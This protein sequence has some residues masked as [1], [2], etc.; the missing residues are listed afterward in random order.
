MNL[1]KLVVTLSLVSMVSLTG[2]SAVGTA[3]KKR[4]LEVSTKMSQTIWLEPAD[5]KTVY[6]QIKNTSDKNIDVESK[7]ISALQAKGYS[8]TQDSKNAQYWIQANVLKVDKMDLREAES[9]LASGYGAAA[10]GAVTAGSV[11]AYNG[12]STGAVLG[13]GIVGGLVGVAADAMVEDTNYTMITD[14]QIGEK[15]AETITT[16]N[17]QALT[18]GTSGYKVQTST[19]TGNRAKYQTRI[20]SNANQV[21][22]KFEKALPELE[23]QLA[24]SI[25]GIL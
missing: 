1:K 20:V 15:T 13:A 16:Q 2:C 22:L 11:A 19:A 4:N 24:K 7:I 5:T 14:I 12:N 18:Q 3:V 8:V 25:A 17:N 9:A 6:L 21:N 23:G 10:L